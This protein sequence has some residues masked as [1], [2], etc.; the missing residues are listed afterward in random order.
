M[1][2]KLNNKSQKTQPS[3]EW[4]IDICIGGDVCGACDTACDQNDSCI[5]DGCIFDCYLDIT[6]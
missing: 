5:T 4:C 6:P 1:F 3:P 2:K